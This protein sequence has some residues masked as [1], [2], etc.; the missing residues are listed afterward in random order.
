MSL[1]EDI[2]L[3]TISDIIR[4]FYDRAFVDPMIGH[5]F[6]NVEKEA[7]IKKQ[8]EFSASLL[9]GPRSFLDKNLRKVH[10][11]LHIRRPH[12]MRR[13]V[14]FS[15]ILRES[16]LTKEQQEQWLALEERLKPLIIN[17]PGT[18]QH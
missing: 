2:G 4:K 3:E 8:I 10:G 15:E 5:F 13:Q 1:F 16:P 12:F 6:F 17:S 18:C 9:G 7:I 11:A 14:L